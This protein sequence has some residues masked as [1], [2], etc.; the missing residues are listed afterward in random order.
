M[1]HY[2]M[3]R[4][5]MFMLLVAFLIGY[6]FKQISGSVCGGRLVEG[7]YSGKCY[8]RP[9]SWE[10]CDE[11]KTS[12][13][14]AVA[15]GTHILTAHQCWNDK[16]CDHKSGRVCSASGSVGNCVDK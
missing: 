6:F 2:K 10:H 5:Q 3:N 8:N 12:R 15:G 4:E 9:N 16:D 13:P 14:V 11:N 7:S 1:L